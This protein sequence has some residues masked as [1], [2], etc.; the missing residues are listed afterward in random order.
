MRFRVL[1]SLVL[2]TLHDLPGDLQSQDTQE[3]SL[4]TK[5]L[6]SRFEKGKIATIPWDW[7]TIDFDSSQLTAAVPEHEE[8]QAV[9][10]SIRRIRKARIQQDTESYLAQAAEDVTLISHQV[11]TKTDGH[12]EVVT[13]PP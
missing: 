10:E 4:A 11:G 5:R 3:P 13:C 6:I 2:A 9:R 7:G 1:L 8:A 12:E